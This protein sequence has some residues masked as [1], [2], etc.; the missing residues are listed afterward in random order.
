M[1]KHI[2][3]FMKEEDGTTAV[4]Y[5]LMIALISAALVGAVTFLGNT[6]TTRFGAVANN[7]ST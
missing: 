5:G 7:I 2:V 1:V 3:R 6:L 4:E